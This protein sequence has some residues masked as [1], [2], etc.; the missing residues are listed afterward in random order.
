[1][2]SYFSTLEDTKFS[3]FLGF[4]KINYLNESSEHKNID[5]IKKIND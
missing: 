1:M 5:L 4:E 2:K 3:N